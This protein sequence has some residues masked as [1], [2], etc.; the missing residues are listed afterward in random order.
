MRATYFNH[1]EEDEGHIEFHSHQSGEVHNLTF[2]RVSDE[3]LLLVD[4]QFVV[5]AD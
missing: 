4:G 1:D 3:P 2:E 5:Y